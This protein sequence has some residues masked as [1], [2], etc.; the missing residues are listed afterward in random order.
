MYAM[1]A[2]A[3]TM[4]AVQVASTQNLVGSPPASSPSEAPTSS[5]I[6]EVTVITVWRELQNSQKT[7]PGN[8]HA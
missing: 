2:I 6:A 3:D 4:S 5:E 7:R 1:R 8:R